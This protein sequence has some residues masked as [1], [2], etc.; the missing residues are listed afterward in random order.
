MKQI[1]K[2]IWKGISLDR[3]TQKYFQK[4]IQKKNNIAGIQIKIKK[5]GCAGFK[6]YLSLI[7]TQEIKK[8]ENFYLYNKNQINIY[9]KY[10]DMHIID[11]TK[12]KFIKNDGINMSIKFDNPKVNEFCG[13]GES[14]S[15]REKK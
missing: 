13:C 4:L 6:Y 15:F 5:S 2:T 8:I 14:F 7:T 3:E 12:I 10:E 11:G 1:K 9:I